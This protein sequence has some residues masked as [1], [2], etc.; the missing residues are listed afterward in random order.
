MKELQMDELE[1]I[2]GGAWTISSYNEATEVGAYGC[3]AGGFV[4]GAMVGGIG[5]IPG[6]AAGYVGGYI[7]GAT[8]WLINNLY[9]S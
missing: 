8:G 3:A 7:A 2:N 6:A 1:N 4:T 5:A 9:N